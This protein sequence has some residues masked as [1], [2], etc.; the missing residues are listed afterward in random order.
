[1]AGSAQTGQ[2]LVA[3]G[4]A[5][6]VRASKFLIPAEQKETR[7]ALARS[8]EII[9]ADAAPRFDKYSSR[10]AAGFRVRVRVRG[11]EVEQSL[12]K[13]TG[14]RPDWGD[15]QMKK[16]LLP[17]LYHNQDEAAAEFEKA[18]DIVTAIFERA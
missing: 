4:Y 9:R 11:V 3:S 13:T 18:I 8:G 5:E 16:G 1:M 6:L 14:A 2:T 7:A 17:A 10:S 12:R 15:L